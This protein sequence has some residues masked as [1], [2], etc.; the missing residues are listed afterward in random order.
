MGNRVMQILTNIDDTKDYTY[1]VHDAQGNIMAI[2]NLS[3]SDP[4]GSESE[5]LNSESE[6][7]ELGEQPIY[8]SS[9]IGT[10]LPAGN[11]STSTTFYKTYGLCHYELT[12]HISTSLNINL[13]NVL[14]VISDWKIKNT[15]GTYSPEIISSQDYYPFGLE[16]PDRGFTSSDMY[17]YSFNG[18]EDDR[19]AGE[20]YQDYGA[21]EYDKTTGRFISFDPLFRNFPWNSPYSFAENC[22]IQA[23]DLDGLE[24]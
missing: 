10:Y 13:G 5:A 7:V 23:I 22:P 19:E 14:A 17:R 6:P 12:N 8:V 21:R 18:K 24:K 1:Y 20:G 11:K 15:D 4:V 2:Y 16:M 9:R 3:E